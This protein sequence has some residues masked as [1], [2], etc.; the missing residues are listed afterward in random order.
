MTRKP[1]ASGMEAFLPWMIYLQEII[2]EQ[3]QRSIEQMKRE[4]AMFQQMDQSV[5]AKRGRKRGVKEAG[6]ARRAAGPKAKK[7]AGPRWR[8][9]KAVGEGEEEATPA[10]SSAIQAPGRGWRR[11]ASASRWDSFTPAQRK[12]QIRKMSQAGKASYAAATARGAVEE[13]R[14][15]A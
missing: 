2:A 7:G 8:G 14:A 15:T 12:A 6:R 13:L 4:L 11:C 1:T 5:V 9:G 3:M 10:R